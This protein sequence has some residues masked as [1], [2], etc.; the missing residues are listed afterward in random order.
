MTNKIDVPTSLVI[1]GDGFVGRA[2]IRQYRL[3]NVKCAGTSRRMNPAPDLA[4]LDLAEPNL[5]AVV[6]DLERFQDAVIVAAEANV[7]RCERDPERSYQIN[8]RGTLQLVDQLITA[9]IRPVFSSSDSVFAGV[10]GNYTEEDIPEPVIHY[11]H[12][13]LET[14]REI[15]ARTGGAGLVL[16]Y[17]K[18]Y[19][20]EKGDGSILDEMATMFAC[21]KQVKA[22]TDQI[23][24]PLL[25]EDLIR[26]VA[27]LQ[28]A[29]AR[30]LVHVC[31]DEAWSRYDIACRLAE[32]MALDPA[33]CVLPISLS[34]LGLERPKN[35]AM[36]NRRMRSY[37]REP[38]MTIEDAVKA[39]A[40]QYRK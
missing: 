14:E 3:W 37:Y 35:I 27:T 19:S 23:F 22:A 2:M 24:C 7:G 4:F 29:D 18:I 31:G 10:E 13:K 40:A 34:D 5:S 26:I 16:R 12:Q 33:E 39:K 21:G 20:L 17:S 28:V 36:I 25:R 30:G 32:A 1:G 6:P 8:V 15:L 38:M 9:G 11:G